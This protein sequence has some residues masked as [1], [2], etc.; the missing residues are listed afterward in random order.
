MGLILR[1]KIDQLIVNVDIS[2]N[3]VP[4]L[5]VMKKTARG[6][7]NILNTLHHD[8]ALFIYDMLIGNSSSNTDERRYHEHSF[9]VNIR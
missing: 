7:F 1:P 5:T 9:R 2:E 4:I 3:D 6:T 8:E